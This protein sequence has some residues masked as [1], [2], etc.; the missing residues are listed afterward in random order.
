ML[1]ETAGNFKNIVRLYYNYRFGFKPKTSE[2]LMSP[3]SDIT[4]F[5]SGTFLEQVNCIFI[6]CNAF[7]IP[8]L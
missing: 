2:M 7:K 3:A 8:K 5:L 4:E 1:F 6:K